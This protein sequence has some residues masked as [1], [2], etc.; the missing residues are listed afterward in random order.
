LEYEDENIVKDL[1][2]NF[3]QQLPLVDHCWYPDSLINLVN[4]EKVKCDYVKDFEYADK[5]TSKP[6]E[7][8]VVNEV[9]VLEH[10]PMSDNDEIR[11][12]LTVRH[13]DDLPNEEECDLPNDSIDLTVSEDAVTSDG[14]NTID[15]QII[16]KFDSYRK[17]K[18]KNKRDSIH[19]HEEVEEPVETLAEA[20]NKYLF[21]VKSNDN[22]FYNRHRHVPVTN[23][24]SIRYGTYKSKSMPSHVGYTPDGLVLLRITK[25]SN[26]PDNLGKNFTKIMLIY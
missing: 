11:I 1:K 16:N 25:H 22:C 5:N 12:K 3:D 7:R 14:E 17:S 8:A 2:I 10:K 23:M 13:S 24:N 26:W 9:K 18:Y 6:I 20:E 21:T 19:L 4:D 15:S